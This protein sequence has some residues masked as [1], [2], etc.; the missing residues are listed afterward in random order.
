[1]I[2]AA[3]EEFSTQARQIIVSLIEIL[4]E[5]IRL[6]ADIV[7]GMACFDPIVLLVLPL[8]EALSYL[9]S[10]YKSFKLRGW[11]ANCPEDDLRDEYLGFLE[12]FRCKYSSFKDN[13]EVFNNM[14]ILLFNIPEFKE[15]KLLLHLFRL[16]CLC[17]TEGDVTPPAVKFP[18]VDSG[19]PRLRLSEAILPAQ[20]YLAQVPGSVT[21]CT[22]EVA[23]SQYIELET[24]FNSG[25]VAGDPWS[26]VEHSGR[27][28]FHK[29]FCSVYNS[30]G[31]AS[32]SASCPVLSSSSSDERQGLR[33]PS[34]RNKKVVFG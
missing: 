28:G 6:N 19:D 34:K 13:L 31:K 27:V 1:M 4:L 3:R 20:S 15:R 10:L 17:L 12:C 18:G 5:D 33:S 29:V 25:N 11:M 14:V 32:A 24:R 8:D 22:N 7:R 16:S 30:S 26:H 2:E 23:L 21:R 9:K